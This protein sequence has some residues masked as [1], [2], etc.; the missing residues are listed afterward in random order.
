MTFKQKLKD[1]LRDNAT[2]GA[3]SSLEE[4]ED[5]IAR[6]LIDSIA[7]LQIILFIEEQTGIRIPDEE[8]APENFQTIGAIERTVERLQAQSPSS[9]AK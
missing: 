8:V 6:G 9:V 4:N 5:L 2:A 3:T 1:F 7:L